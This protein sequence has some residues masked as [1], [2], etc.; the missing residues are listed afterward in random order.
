MD[1]EAVGI[2][3]AANGRYRSRDRVVSKTGCMG[4]DQNLICAI[5]GRQRSGRKGEEWA[6][7]GA[8]VEE[9]TAQGK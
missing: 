8:G 1:R 4:E 3:Q 6:Q 9:Q 5:K 2:A 7:D